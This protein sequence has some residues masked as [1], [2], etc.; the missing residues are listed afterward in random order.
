MIRT[1]ES[2]DEL[3]PALAKAQA[4]F[5]VISLN[6]RVEVPHKTGGKHEYWYAELD[7]I[8]GLI[9]PILTEF[10]FS[11]IQM[12]TAGADG[13]SVLTTRVLHS[14]GQW[15]E[16]DAPLS[17]GFMA[18]QDY[19]SQITYL[20]RYCQVAALDLRMGGDDDGARAQNA[21][22]RQA[23]REAPARPP[24][25]PKPKVEAK[26]PVAESRASSEQIRIVWGL[27]KGGADAGGLGYADGDAIAFITKHTGKKSTAGLMATDVIKLTAAIQAERRALAAAVGAPAPTAGVGTFDDF[28]G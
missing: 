16:S 6:R 21:A 5:P 13:G 26:G 4:K 17:K 1:S 22:E 9:R 23:R 18:A 12:A 27:L 28:P 25:A 3:A 20:R 11:V 15:Y 7:H 24:V 2:L 14:S 10:E 19:G 8:Q